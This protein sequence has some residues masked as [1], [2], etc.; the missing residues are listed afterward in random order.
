MLAAPRRC[1]KLRSIFRICPSATA[2]SKTCRSRFPA[3][4]PIARTLF[5]SSRASLS[6]FCK[7]RAAWTWRPKRVVYPSVEPSSEFVEILPGLQ[8]ALESLYKG[9]GQ[10]LYALRDYMANDSVRHV[11]WKASARSRLADGARIHARRRLPRAARAR[12]ARFFDAASLAA[13]PR[14]KP[15]ANASSAPSRCAPR[16]PG[17]SMNATPQLQFRSAGVETRLAPAEEIVFTILRTWRWP[18]RCRPTPS[19]EL[20]SD[21]AASP[22]LFKIIVTSQPRGSIPATSGTPRYVIFLDDLSAEAPVFALISLTAFEVRADNR[23]CRCLRDMP[24]SHGHCRNSLTLRTRLLE[25]VHQ[26]TN[27]ILPWRRNRDPYRI[28]ISEIMLQQTRVAAV[29][30]YFERFCAHFPDVRALAERRKKRKCCGCGRDLATTA[31]REICRRRE[32][33]CREARRRF[34]G[35]AAERFARLR[36]IGSTPPTQF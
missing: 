13:R 8:G 29:I 17:T 36:G 18:T 14:R 19:I 12:S 6:A 3:A 21:L 15:P 31:A 30:P 10:D 20:L 26:L 5:A 24:P 22:G 9:R 2:C 27:A 32:T 7:K 11:H 34:S 35:H 16:S 23:V 28:W 1:S 33:D 4:A 25:L